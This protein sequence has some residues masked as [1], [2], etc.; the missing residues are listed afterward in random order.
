VLVEARD[1]V[2][3]VVVVKADPLRLAVDQDLTPLL[4]LVEAPFGGIGKAYVVFSCAQC[5][6]TP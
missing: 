4:V 1:R 6:S 5:L 3:L 2:D